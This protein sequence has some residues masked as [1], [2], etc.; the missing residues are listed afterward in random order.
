MLFRRQGAFTVGKRCRQRAGRW[1]VV[2]SEGGGSA[3]GVKDVGQVKGVV[4]EG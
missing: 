1:Q 3:L 2:C 4:M